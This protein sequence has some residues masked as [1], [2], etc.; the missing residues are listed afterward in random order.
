MT[1]A[2]RKDQLAAN[3]MRVRE[4]IAAAA[5]RR[6][7][8]AP[9]LIVV[10]KFFP[11]SDVAALAE[12]EVRDVGENRDQ[13]AAAKAAEL[14][15]VAATSGL[16]WHFIG[17]LQTNKAKSVVR[18]AYAVHSVDRLSLVKALSKAMAVEQARR[19]EQGGQPREDLLVLIQVDLE[20][21]TA[22]GAAGSSGRGG[23]RPEEIGA[24]AAA[25]SEADGLDLGGLMAVAPLGADPAEAFSRLMQYSADLRRTHPSAGMV[26]AGMSQD[27]EAAVAAGA[28]HLR[29][30][31]D[32]LGPRPPVM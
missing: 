28:T 31:S 16:R 18:Y 7:G 3:L 29:V 12:L 17:Q 25:V 32:V 26:S 2:E 20:D 30:G 1:D 13:E 9:E 4:R 22:Q 19:T 21:R 27:L 15:A 23:A 14:E 10:T 11:A 6:S 24:L 8:P 5:A